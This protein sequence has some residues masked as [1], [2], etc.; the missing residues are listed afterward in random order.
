MFLLVFVPLERRFPF[1]RQQLR[2]PG[3]KTDVIY[4]MTGC[5][6]GQFSDA[7]SLAAMLLVRQATGLNFENVAATQP[8]WVQFLEILVLSDFLAYTYHRTV[9]TYPWLWQ[10]HK[11]HHSVRQMDWLSGIRVHPV[12]KVLGDLFQFTPLFL[13]EFSNGPLLAYTIWLGFQSFLNH[14]NVKINFGPLR[15]IFSSPE[16][17]HWHHCDDPKKYPEAHHKN[18]A[19]HLV[20]FD[21]LFGTAY[22]RPDRAVPEKYGISEAVPESFWRQM[23]YPLRRPARFFRAS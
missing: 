17:H 15:W 13:L 2:R 3:W 22:L 4:Y 20:V 10:L 7:A 19:P 23:V 6:V 1:R 9:H 21:L 18:F 12:D 11:I 14:S 16:F 5:F 8:G